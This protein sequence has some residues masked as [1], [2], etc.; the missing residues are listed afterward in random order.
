MGP[1][2][3]LCRVPRCSSTSVNPFVRIIKAEIDIL[4]GSALLMAGRGFSVHERHQMLLERSDLILK[5]LD[6][7]AERSTKST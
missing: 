6:R 3:N 1:W 5:G 7:L 4:R 2:R